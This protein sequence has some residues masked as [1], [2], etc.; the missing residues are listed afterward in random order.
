MLKIN[1]LGIK[2]A[3]LLGYCIFMNINIEGDFQIC[4]S[5]PLS[6]KVERHVLKKIPLYEI[7]RDMYKFSLI[8]MC[9]LY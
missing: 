7:I 5:V 1:L 4:I 6:M 2:N 8:T 9:K 3:K